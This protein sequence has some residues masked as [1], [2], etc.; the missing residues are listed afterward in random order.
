MY[1][2][3]FYL[4]MVVFVLF[5]LGV[6][7]AES[8]LSFSLL[9]PDGP[10]ALGGVIASAGL[11]YFALG[12]GLRRRFTKILCAV[13]GLA[14]V[15]L[16]G[17]GFVSPMYFGFLSAFVRIDDLLIMFLSGIGYLIAGLE[18]DRPSLAQELGLSYR[19]Y[20]ARHFSD[21]KQVRQHVH[22][23]VRHRHSG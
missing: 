13:V 3:V 11:I 17:I 20:V 4:G 15:A 18:Y 14:L 19:E 8:P 2:T 22:I 21:A 12:S 23:H 16:A 6:V 5:G 1:R 10:V 7:L 9:L